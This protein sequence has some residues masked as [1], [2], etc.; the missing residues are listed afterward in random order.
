MN[1]N[2]FY[3]DRIIRTILA[4]AILGLYLFKLIPVGIAPVLLVGAAVFFVTGFTGFCPLYW[5]VGLKG[6]RKAH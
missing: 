3:A 5:V 1:S 4:F 2:M 6:K